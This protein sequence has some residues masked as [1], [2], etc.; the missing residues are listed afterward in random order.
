MNLRRPPRSP[1][2][3]VDQGGVRLD[4]LDAVFDS[5]LE[6]RDESRAVAESYRCWQTSAR[7]DREDAFARYV[8]AL[9]R[10][11][12]AARDYGNSVEQARG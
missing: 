10:E 12:H 3:R 5:Y 6:W 1:Q 11:E 9:D 2:S 4:L 8:A 7:A